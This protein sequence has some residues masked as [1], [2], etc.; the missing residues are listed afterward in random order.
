MVM[1]DDQSDRVGFDSSSQST[2]PFLGSHYRHDSNAGKGLQQASYTFKI[3]KAGKYKLQI[4]WTA[5]SNRATN[6][7]IHLATQAGK[8][9]IVLNQRQKPQQPPFGT[10]GIF[11]FAPGLVTVE[12]DN[13][14]TD[15]YVIL[16][17]ARI[18]AVAPAP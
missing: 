14:S 15:G 6:V 16:D 8:R 7:P 2:G 1:D 9:T 10:L 3:T 17:G 12:I 5:H 18:V 13:S 4:A 11:D